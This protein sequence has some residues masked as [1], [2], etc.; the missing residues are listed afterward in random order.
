[1]TE[2]Q[3]R[4][5]QRVALQSW[6]VSTLTVELSV[7]AIELVAKDG[8]ADF[9]QMHTDLMVAPGIELALHHCGIT[10]SLQYPYPGFGLA[11]IAC[12]FFC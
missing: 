2:L 6:L 10:T 12:V 7:G 9:R 4:C 5:M 11:G 8:V 1:M 3:T